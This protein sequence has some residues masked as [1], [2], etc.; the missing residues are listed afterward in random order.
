MYYYD[1][2]A[3]ARRG[4]TCC[5]MAD[6]DDSDAS[7]G[8]GAGRAGFSVPAW[9]RSSTKATAQRGKTARTDSDG[10]DDS[11]VQPAVDRFSDDED[12]DDADDDDDHSGDEKEDEAKQIAEQ[13]ERAAL[14]SRTTRGSS[15][16]GPAAVAAQHRPAHGN[17]SV[18]PPAPADSDDSSSGDH[19]H[20]WRR[21][22]RG[23]AVVEEEKDD[24]DD[25]DNDNSDGEDAAADHRA[26]DS[27][28]DSD[29]SSFVPELTQKY[30]P[31]RASAGRR[32][33]VIVMSPNLPG[34][35]SAASTVSDV[36]DSDASTSGGGPLPP[37]RG[38]LWK[39]GGGTTWIFGRR[40][41][42]RRWFIFDVEGM[43]MSYYKSD[44]EADA[45]KKPIG[46]I[47]MSVVTVS[48]VT[49][50]RHKHY[51]QVRGPPAATAL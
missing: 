15:Q 50:S 31:R 48:V 26:A 19:D 9:L 46:T 16:R 21:G 37:V 1:C 34:G 12:D 49:G 43:L 3:A 25:S 35:A 47:D 7:G 29:D 11:Q 33:S 24:D 40:N 44:K 23:R 38:W 13:A 39:K 30:T 6:S 22:N 2:P 18:S 20:V 28:A 17:R 45:G 14:F 36:D 32:V 8:G 27:V 41:W 42:K 51:V 10:S 5:R 4:T